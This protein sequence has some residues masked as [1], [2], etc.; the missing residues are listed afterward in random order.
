MKQTKFYHALILTALV[1]MP[2]ISYLYGDDSTVTVNADK[3][4]RK[5]DRSKLIGTNMALWD[6]PPRYYLPET[7]RLLRAWKP[8]TVR[9]PGGSWSDEYFWNGNGVMK[10]VRKDLT[11]GY[12]YDTEIDESKFKNGKWEID[13]SGYAPGFRINKDGTANAFH[14]NFDIKRMLDYI[15][16]KIGTH[17]FITVNAGTGTAHMAEEWVKWTNKTNSYNVKYWEIG[18]ELEGK[19]ETGHNMPDGTEMTGEIYAK[20]FAEFAKAMKSVDNNIKVGGAAGGDAFRGFTESMLKYAGEDVDFVSFHYYPEKQSITSDKELFGHIDR[21]GTIVRRYREMI[22]KYQPERADKI[23][24]GI[25]EW[26]CKLSEDRQTGDM[27]SGLWTCLFVGEMLKTGLNFANQWDIFT[28]KEKGG[29]CALHFTG[30]RIIPKSQYWGF[31]LWA[32]CMSDTALETAVSGGNGKLK[33]I[34]TRSKDTLSVMLVNL[35]RE[36]KTAA[37]LKIKGFDFGKKAETYLFSHRSYLW[38]YIKNQPQWSLEPVRNII[39]FSDNTQLT[40]PPFS[41]LVVR[42]YPENA[43]IAPLPASQ[44]IYPDIQYIVP[45]KIALNQKTEAWITY[46]RMGNGDP[47][48]TDFPFTLKVTRG[49]AEITPSTLDLS[50]AAAPFYIKAD[51]PGHITI[52]GFLNGQPVDFPPDDPPIYIK[53]LPQM[54]KEKIF[55]NFESDKE[56]G[57]FSSKYNTAKDK[58]VRRQS[59]VFAVDFDSGKKKSDMIFTITDL[60]DHFPKEDIAGVTAEVILSHDFKAP[61]SAELSIVLQS[62][63]CY[64]IPLGHFSLN[65]ISRNSD[66]PTKITARV[67]AEFTKAV[68]E[69]FSIR[70]HVSSQKTIQGKIYF[71]NIGFILDQH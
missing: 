68:S 22:K 67:P 56:P 55:W 65:S 26:N 30:N 33:V 29:H 18:N 5:G 64:W 23:E 17:A 1:S 69:T 35:S 51:K 45:K 59:T 58:N 44:E 9:I 21:F 57:V 20:R 49:D 28:Q 31:W 46:R 37:K 43:K 12:Q 6:Y 27:T 70:F 19:W 10:W 16:N 8:G 39:D 42:L 47:I 54:E 11:G 63:Q 71:D 61:D 32:N 36:E 38:N 2:F 62:R 66:D 50:D 4:I 34:A 13:Y 41:A 53:V 52:E 25:S 14:G 3:I 40:L 60:P 24:L 48:P 7:V 15:Y